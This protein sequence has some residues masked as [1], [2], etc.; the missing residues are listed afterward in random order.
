MPPPPPPAT[1]QRGRRPTGDDLL[2]PSCDSGRPGWGPGQTPRSSLSMTTMSATAR[3][4]PLAATPR[5]RR[6]SRTRPAT[7][8]LLVRHGTTPSTGQVLPGRAPG[9]H[10]ADAGREQAARLGDRLA[11]WA[12][13]MGPGPGRRRVR[14]PARRAPRAAAPLA[15]A[16]GLRVRV[17]RGLIECDFGDVDRRR[18]ESADEAS[19]WTTVQRYPSGFRFPGGESLHSMQSAPSTGHR[20]TWSPRHPG[21]TVVA[22]S[23]ADPHQGRP[24][25]CPGGSSRPVPARG[26]LTS[27]GQHHQLWSRRPMVLAVNSSAALPRLAPDR[28]RR[29]GHDARR[30]T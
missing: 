14:L 5:P 6:R 11:A 21:A 12:P 15:A 22:V 4:V 17:A 20:S 30:V 24:V 1:H 19:E 3:S 9:L 28:P 29:T 18:A 27:L 8:I 7:L 26:R 23:H 10:L 25:S 2:P 16:L 13:P